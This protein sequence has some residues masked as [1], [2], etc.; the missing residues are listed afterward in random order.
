MHNNYFNYHLKCSNSSWKFWVILSHNLWERASSSWNPPRTTWI[1]FLVCILG[2]RTRMGI[3]RNFSN[4]KTKPAPLHYPLVVKSDRIASLEDI[5]VWGS[6]NQLHCARWRSHH[7]DSEAGCC[8]NIQ[9]ICAAG[10][11]ALH[12]LKTPTS[13]ATGP[14]VGLLQS[15]LIGGYCKSQA[16]DRG[17]NT[18]GGWCKDPPISHLLEYEGKVAEEHIEEAACRWG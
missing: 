6:T 3:L 15:R 18:D 13:N 2:A 10:L 14:G 5:K 11:C 12:S 16:R 17:E 1:C 8:Q 9:R 4:M 7:L